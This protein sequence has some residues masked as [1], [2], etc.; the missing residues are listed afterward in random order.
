MPWTKE[1]P[2]ERRQKRGTCFVILEVSQAKKRLADVCF[3]RIQSLCSVSREV[4]A[5][6]HSQALHPNH[7]RGGGFLQSGTLTPVLPEDQHLFGF[8]LLNS[9]EFIFAG[10]ELGAKGDLELRS[11]S[12]A[13]KG[14]SVRV[15]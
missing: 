9:T 15:P 8:R 3:G 6:E 2:G 5:P 11:A 12:P 13:P 10:S 7:L 1:P 14:E 4:D